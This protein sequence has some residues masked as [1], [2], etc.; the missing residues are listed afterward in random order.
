MN[1]RKIYLTKEI[2]DEPRFDEDFVMKKGITI[3]KILL[4]LLIVA[5]SLSA[6]HS[7]K[8]PKCSTWHTCEPVF[9]RT[10]N[11]D[12]P[13]WQGIS[14][15]ETTLDEAL[16][17][18]EQLTFLKSYTFVD[19]ESESFDSRIILVDKQDAW[20]GFLYVLD[21]K[22]AL[23]SFSGEISTSMEE[24][25]ELCSGPKKVLFYQHHR[26]GAIIEVFDFEKGISFGTSDYYSSFNHKENYLGPKTPVNT[27][28]L[29]DPTL[30]DY[31]VEEGVFFDGDFETGSF[32]EALQDWNGYGRP[33]ELYNQIKI[34]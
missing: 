33:L 8:K 14:P 9:T 31:F 12:L 23:M 2:M 17:T 24:I 30:A 34:D 13:C 7:W 3:N 5:L 29:F 26:G 22:I 32:M 18:L 11:C 1:T 16:N 28:I 4:I 27:L 20:I 25:T 10:N 19:E 21:G 6:C 15:G